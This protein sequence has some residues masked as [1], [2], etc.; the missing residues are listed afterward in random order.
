MFVILFNP[1]CLEIQVYHLSVDMDEERIP[2]THRT[3][4]A[5]HNNLT[6]PLKVYQLTSSLSGKFSLK[7]HFQLQIQSIVARNR[8]LYFDH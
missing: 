5:I 8:D 1:R 4:I 7:S 2:Y 6:S 3:S